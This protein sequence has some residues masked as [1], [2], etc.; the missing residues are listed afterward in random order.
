MIYFKIPYSF[1]TIESLLFIETKQ[2]ASG[3]TINRHFT[4]FF[5]K[6]N[7]IYD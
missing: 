7:S 1:R 6:K 3:I 4:R 5:Y 2:M